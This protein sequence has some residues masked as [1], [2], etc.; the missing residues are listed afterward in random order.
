MSEFNVF[1][2]RLELYI[3]LR[4]RAGHVLDRENVL[5]TCIEPAMHRAG[6]PGFSIEEI[7]GYWEGVREQTIRITVFD[8]TPELESTARLEGTLA[9]VCATLADELD[10][11][12]ILLVSTPAVGHLIS[13]D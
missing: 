8:S 4:T 9:S 12:A 2:T 1:D 10:Q 5:T 6:I 3:G 11:D 7:T 13:R